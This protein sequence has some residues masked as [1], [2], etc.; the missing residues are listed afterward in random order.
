MERLPFPL[1][2]ATNETAIITSVN[3]EHFAGCPESGLTNPPGN[4]I[5][6]YEADD[7]QQRKNTELKIRSRSFPNASNL[8]RLFVKNGEYVYA[9]SSDIIMMES[10][11][12]LVK[13]YL[14]FNEKIKKTVRHNTLKVTGGVTSRFV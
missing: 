8:F 4:A 2:E 9:K 7:P 12:H 10:C 11:D 6:P 3:N 14:S 13:V 1:M 5:K